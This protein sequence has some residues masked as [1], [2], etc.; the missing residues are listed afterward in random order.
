MSQTEGDPE[1]E[2]ET[3]PS[4]ETAAQKDAPIVFEKTKETE[5]SEETPEVSPAV[6]VSPRQGDKTEEAEEI[7]SGKQS[8]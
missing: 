8:L 3:S 4:Q 7:P 2:Q 6:S 1:A 5:V